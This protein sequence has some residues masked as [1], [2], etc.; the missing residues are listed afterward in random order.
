M[1]G[2]AKVS[3]MTGVRRQAVCVRQRTAAKARPVALMTALMQGDR[4]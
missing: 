2:L 1:I 4:S 3:I